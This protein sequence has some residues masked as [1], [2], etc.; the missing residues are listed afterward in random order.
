MLTCVIKNRV[1]NLS[2][3]Q[4]TVSIDQANNMRFYLSDDLIACSTQA[5]TRTQALTQA[6]DILLST[7]NAS[8]EQIERLLIQHDDMT[9]RTLYALA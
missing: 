6:R 9:A 2:F 7:H 5:Q 3:H 8:E 1:W 4:V